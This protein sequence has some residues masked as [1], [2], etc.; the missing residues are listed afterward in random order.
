LDKAGLRAT[1]LVTPYDNLKSDIKRVEDE[2][3]ILGARWAILPWIDHG[4]KFEQSDVDRSSK[5]M[6]TW[7]SALTKAGYKF[8]YHP[9]GYEFQPSPGG[10]LFDTLA[11]ATD[12]DTVKFEMD[13]FWIVWPGQDCAELMKR[14]PARFRLL[15]LK[16]LRKGVKTGDLGGT[17]PDEYSV[18]VG[19]GI[20]PWKDVLTLAQQQ[21]FEGYYIEDESPDAAT[22][23]VSSLKF[24]KSLQI[25]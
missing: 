8:A 19:D 15:H 12:P 2:L 24:L 16:D 14:Y 4:K 11:R 3:A 21:K 5:D 23:I 18:A 6:N 25:G 10:T 9:H 17:A 13:T 20:V 22:Q 7:G 1:A